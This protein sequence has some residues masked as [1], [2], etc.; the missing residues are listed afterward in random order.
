MEC[1]VVVYWNLYNPLDPMI[2]YLSLITNTL[3]SA[4]PIYLFPWV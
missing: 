4:L 3:W 2:E 1:E